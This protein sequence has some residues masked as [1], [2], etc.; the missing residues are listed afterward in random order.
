MAMTQRYVL[1]MDSR[2]RGRSAYDRDPR[3]YNV[4]VELSDVIAVLTAFDVGRAVVVGTSRGGSW[5][6][7]SPRRGRLRWPALSSTI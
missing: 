5:P 2:G 7:C 4:A 3:N 6:C 1:T